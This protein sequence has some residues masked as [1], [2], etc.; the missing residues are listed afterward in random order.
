M[1]DLPKTQVPGL[2][3][4]RIGNI[5][6]TVV[7]DGFLNGSNAALQNI[8][9]DDAARMLTEAFRPTPRCGSVNT[10]LIRS[11]GRTALIDTGRGPSL[12]PTAGQLFHN[13]AA[14]GVDPA[15]ID[16][17]LMTHLHPDHSNGLTD[18]GGR[19]MFPNAG[20]SMHAA[21]QAYWDDPASAARAA[22]T[23]QGV[24]YFAAVKVQLSPSPAAAPV[25]GR[26]GLSR[27]DGYAAPRPYSGSLRL[28]DR[29]RQGN[30]AG[31]GRHRSCAGDTGTLSGDRH[32]VRCRAGAGSRN[33][34]AD[35]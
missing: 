18:A 5:L 12:Q 34:P 11:G 35:L 2:Y 6:V 30:A 8:S 4:R 25:R 21:E 23:G 10:F 27:C 14:A 26:R 15:E 1:A 29:I 22:E 31:L 13:L 33:A 3:H 9:G 24:P 32:A 19:A 28:H 16:T 17:I 20:V 7:S